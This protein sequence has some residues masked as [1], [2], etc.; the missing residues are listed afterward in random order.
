M[1]KAPR[2]HLL[3]ALVWPGVIGSSVPNGQCV[4]LED[5]LVLEH[6]SPAA[7]DYARIER[8]IRTG[9]TP[10][11]VSKWTAIP[12]GK[13]RLRMTWSN[14]FKRMLPEVMSVPQFTGVRFHAGDTVEQTDGCVLLGMDYKPGDLVHSSITVEHFCKWL[15][16][17][18]R[19]DEV[20]I[21]V[22]NP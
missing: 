11:K 12:S 10:V 18:E 5:A 19:I 4:T 13:Y 20:W 22:T 3:G 16:D 21:R 7:P 17:A 9:T 15:T 8:C 6:Q 14:R 1:T 2:N